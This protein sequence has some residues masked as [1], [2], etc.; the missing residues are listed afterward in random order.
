MPTFRSPDLLS[1]D[2]SRLLIIDLQE[3]LLAAMPDAT[4]VLDGCLLLVQAARRLGVPVHAT[5]QYPRG[6]GPTVEPLRGLVGGAAVEKLRFSA[7]GCFEWGAAAGDTDRPQVVLAGIEAHVCVLQT[8]LDL[9]A[10]GF[11]VSVVVDA[12]ASRHP[13][14]AQV[15]LD[16]LRDQGA[17]LTTAE[18]VLFEWCEAAGTPEF[19]ELSAWVKAR[20]AEG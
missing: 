13:R 14:D 18:S 9:M 12:V 20:R 6:L 15:A 17:T 2:A 7:A 16:R 10:C 5:E 1:R 19:K 4:A 11:R 3:R 8:A